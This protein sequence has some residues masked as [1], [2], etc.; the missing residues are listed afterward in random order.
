M[1]NNNYQNNNYY[2]AYQ[3]GGVSYPQQQPVNQPVLTQLLTPEE[4]M[5]LQKS[6]PSFHTKLSREEYLRS[7]CTHKSTDN[8]F[9]LDQLPNGKQRCR[10]CGAEFNLIP[11]GTP[12][13][14]IEQICFNFN[15]LIQS[16]KTYYGNPPKDMKEFYL[17]N[18]FTDKIGF[19]WDIAVKY[20]DNITKS[21]NVLQQ[22]GE[23]YAFGTLANILGPGPMMNPIYYPN[24]QPVYYPQ[25]PQ[26]YYY[27]TPTANP[28]APYGAQ[29][30]PAAMVQQPNANAMYNPQQPQ[31][32]MAPMG[33]QN[34]T[35]FNGYP[36]QP[37]YG[38]NNQP[39]NPA[40]VSGAQP[41]SMNPIGYVEPQPQPDF[42][43]NNQQQTVTQTH[44]VSVP[45]PGPGMTATTQ[46]AQTPLP[47]APKN[48]N[49]K[50]NKTKKF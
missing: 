44:K 26:Q 50:E 25:A 28:T 36:Q 30:P 18:G 8:T 9:A 10:V 40:Q 22:N 39:V 29:M 14:E 2:G 3:N 34:G 6:S 42:T 15:D 7:I 47:D 31:Q 5:E 24:Q 38:Y 17:I 1:Y 16:I 37:M 19:L 49:L 12:K 48:P 11:I 35:A 41:N 4:Q 20:F 23:N 45:M 32:P 27:G 21:Q 33:V 13:E 43:A 46:P